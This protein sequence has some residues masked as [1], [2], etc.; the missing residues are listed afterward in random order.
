MKR[1]GRNNEGVSI[2]TYRKILNDY[3]TPDERVQE[4]LDY[5]REFL[6][7]IIRIELDKYQSERISQKSD[8]IALKTESKNDL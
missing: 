3:E 1:T 2:E 4:R 6:R 7:N 5:L 8:N